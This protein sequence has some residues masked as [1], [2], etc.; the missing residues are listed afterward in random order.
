MMSRPWWALC[1]LLVCCDG[2]EP[3]LPELTI[4]ESLDAEIR[5]LVNAQLEKAR[6]D[7]SSP[8]PLGQLGLVFEANVLWRQARQ[9]FGAAAGLAPHDPVW[10]YHAARASQFMGD[11]DGAFTA[12]Q[13]VAERFP[14]FAPAQHHLG[15]LLLESGNIDGAEAA[16]QRAVTL[17]EKSPEGHVG[18]GRVALQR[19]EYAAAVTAL[20]H[21][22]SLDPGHR[23]AAFLVGRAYR[24][25]GRTE[26]ADRVQAQ[27]Q[28]AEKTYI[29][30]RTTNDLPRYTRGYSA[31]LDQ[32]AQLINAGSPREAI[33]L[34]E[35]MHGDRPRDTNIMNNLGVAYRR[36]NRIQD[37]LAILDKSVQADPDAFATYI[38]R[39]LILSALRRYP[40]ALAA[41]DAGIERSPETAHAHYARGKALLF[42]EEFAEA[43]GALATAV[44]LDNRT[45]IFHQAL[46]E[47]CLRLEDSTGARAALEEFLRLSPRDLV[48]LTTLGIVCVNLEDWVGAKRALDTAR[49]LDPN[50]TGVKQ[51]EKYY[52]ERKP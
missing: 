14:N 15:E 2:R 26:D 44:G 30:D 41:A 47:A 23:M 31:R 35:K 29:P 1:W 12:M 28:N 48:G 37:A 43:R 8:E 38:N 52:A 4:P 36:V 49:E 18:L 19:R 45:P 17:R 27:G 10:A 11:F 32:A 16:F 42:M 22:L 5:S 33:V 25:L 9:C 39:S 13:V 21:A 51:L 3:Q 34:L 40:E 6:E 7:P 24:R 50:A 46:A 20:E